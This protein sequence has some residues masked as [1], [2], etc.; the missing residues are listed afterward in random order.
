LKAQKAV[1]VITPSVAGGATQ[2]QSNRRFATPRK[3][4]GLIP[5]ER[6]VLSRVVSVWVDKQWF[7]GIEPIMMTPRPFFGVFQRKE[8]S[9]AGRLA[10]QIPAMLVALHTDEQKV[11]PVISQP[12]IA[13]PFDACPAALLHSGLGAIVLDLKWPLLGFTIGAFVPL[14]G[15]ERLP[16]VSRCIDV[17]T[18]AEILVA[19]ALRAGGIVGRAEFLGQMPTFFPK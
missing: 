6:D 11:R 5:V 3:S 12:V 17:L 7:F 4:G 1:I 8:N 14:R 13:G 16:H 10:T 19:L 15:C 18:K 9:L 2:Q